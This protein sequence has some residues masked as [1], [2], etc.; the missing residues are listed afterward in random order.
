MS[1]GKQQQ[2]QHKSTHTA[3]KDTWE[4]QHVRDVKQTYIYTEETAWTTLL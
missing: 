3:A 1:I 4:K 2:K